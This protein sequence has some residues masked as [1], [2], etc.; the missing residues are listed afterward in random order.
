MG[1][2]ERSTRKRRKKENIQKAVLAAVAVTGTLAIGMLAPKIF[3]ALPGI[4]GKKR[5]KLAFQTR[6]AAGRLAVKGYIRFVGKDGRKRIE[7]T[8]AG[9]RAFAV[10]EATALLATKH[11][12]R[13]DKR[14]RLVMFDIPQ[15]R[16]RDRDH[17]REVVRACGFL[18]LQDSVWVFP[19]DCEELVTL[20][21]ADMKIGKDVLYAIVES[22]ENDGWIKKHFGL[23]K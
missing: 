22:I 20:L 14:W 12:K 1:N 13:W 3:I 19:Y 17:L 11:P 18:R 21:K 16:R 10:E 5:Y 15:H 7:I 9:R 23:S 8:E 4:M 6:T 2:L